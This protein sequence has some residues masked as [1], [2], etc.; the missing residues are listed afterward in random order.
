MGVDAAVWIIGGVCDVRS[1]SGTDELTDEG[2]KKASMF[3]LA[4]FLPPSTVG[5]EGSYLPA[6]QEVEGRVSASTS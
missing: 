6:H 5:G 1:S 3:M 4:F 2:I